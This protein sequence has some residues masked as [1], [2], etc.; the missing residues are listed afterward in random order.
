MGRQAA[1]SGSLFWRWGLNIYENDLP[2]PYGVSVAREQSRAEQLAG[3][4]RAGG[5]RPSVDNDAPRLPLTC[6]C[7]APRL[8]ACWY[9]MPACWLQAC[10]LST[11]PSSSSR[12]TRGAC[13]PTCLPSR[14][15]TS[16]SSSAGCPTRRCLACCGGVSAAL[17]C[18]LARRLAHCGR[19]YAAAG[20]CC[21]TAGQLLHDP[22]A[23]SLSTCLPPS[24]S[25]PPA[26]L[27]CCLPASRCELRPSVCAEHR[28]QRQYRKAFD[29]ESGQLQAHVPP[30]FASQAECCRPGLG[31]FAAGC[32][33]TWF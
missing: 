20:R 2:G 27:R 32:I 7:A 33:T 31:G 11:R 9:R 5:P 30:V 8:P 6:S 24:A 25:L 15:A 29:E 1:L 22:C 21:R 17:A 13:G 16:A 18:L 23:H 12:S 3:G 19:C 10:C 26:A 14:P 28:A 4:R